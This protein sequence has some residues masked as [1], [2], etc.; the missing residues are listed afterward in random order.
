[1]WTASDNL[2]S[3]IY[4]EATR[5][6]GDLRL[7]GYSGWRLPTIDE[8]QGI[9]DKDAEAA[10]ENP[11]TDW[12]QPTAW[13]FHVKGKLFL[14]GRQFSSTGEGDDGER[15]RDYWGFDFRTGS[16][17]KDKTYH[18]RDVRVLCVRESPE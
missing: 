3:L 9:Y 14:T 10:G 11:R 5:Y 18:F 16:R 2:R 13:L 1:M 8:L 4:W 12:Q 6:C 17:F 7:A 15:A